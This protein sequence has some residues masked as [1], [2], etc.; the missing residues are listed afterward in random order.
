MREADHGAP[1]EE[2]GAAQAFEALRAEVARLREG[3]ELVY[4][5]GQEAKA[6][7]KSAAGPGAAGSGVDYRLTL[8][9]MQKSLRE[10]EGRLAAIEDKPALT[11]TPEVY[12]ARIEDMG[13]AAGQVAGK[14]M[15]EGATAQSQATRELKEMLGRARSKRGQREWLITT[16][17]IGVM[18][19]MLLWTLLVE[20]LPWGMGTWLAAVPIAGDKWDAG[21]ELLR[22]AS[23]ASY[24]KMVTLY[25]TCGT[26]TVEFCQEAIA[27]KT[28]ASAA[29]KAGSARGGSHREPRP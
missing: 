5:Q 7:T 4:R 28:I 23:P 9:Q 1:E 16:G 6:E 18:V 27:A 11:M 3:I 25:N 17:L 15:S 22:E 13:R 21:Q 12:R 8:G 26:Q 24:E 19:G 29:G 14:A 20:N 10:V 2:D